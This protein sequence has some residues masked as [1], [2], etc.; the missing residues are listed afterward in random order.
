M[1]VSFLTLSINR[2]EMTKSTWFKNLENATVNLRQGVEFEYLACDNGSSDIRMPEFWKNCGLHY[3]RRNK[4]NEGVGRAF[5]Q[6]FLRSTG[7]I[8][9]L[10]GPD[11]LNSPGWLE[12]CIRYATAVKR[13]GVIGIDWG[14][15]GIPALADRGGIIAHWLTPHLNRIFGTCVFR[16]ELVDSV[17]L[18]HEGF[19]V[20]GLED[21]D[22]NER[23][24][25]SGFTS[26]YVPN[27]YIRCSHLAHDVG[28]NSEYRKMKDKS[29][30][31]NLALFHDRVAKYDRGELGFKEP[32][33]PMREP[34]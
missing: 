3:F 8:I 30:G 22:W 32:L 6:L 31:F 20:Y 12:E 13:S 29:M 17:G 24:N 10:I 34:T 4:T 27:N 16:R 2:F 1:K 19:D 9:C 5:N 23:V 14:H 7:D 21:S 15:G 28:E 18:F 11:L 25:R 26:L 33:P